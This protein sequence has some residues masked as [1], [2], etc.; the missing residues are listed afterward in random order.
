MKQFFALLHLQLLSR[1]ADL[2]PRNLKANLRGKK[3]KTIGMAFAYV[4]LTA[5]LLGLVIYLETV[6]L[7]VLIQMNAPDMLIT[8]AVS[9]SV[10]C[11]L[12]MAFFFIMSSLY[13]GRDTAFIASLPV[14]TRTVL[15]A[16][17]IQ[18]WI[19]EAG[20]AAFFILPASILYGIRLHP[21]P[22]FYLRMILVWLGVPVLPIVIV[23]FLST[24]LIR[25]SA[26]WKKRE[27]VVTVGGI[28]LLVAYMLLCMNLGS[29]TGDHPEE[30]FA[31]FL[32]SNMTRIQ[33]LTR[34]FP[35][36]GWAA[37][38]LLGDWG[39]L[40]LFLAVCAA[41]MAFAVWA[42]GF[43]YH[44]LSLLQSE[45]PAQRGK[46][47]AKALSFSGSSAFG[48]CCQREIRQILRVP[49]YA[50]NIL[51]IS[52]M[53]LL[54]V[55]VM[56][57]SLS[58]S[59]AEQGDTIAQLLEGVGGGTVLAV[60]AAIMAFMAGMNPAL[61]SAVTRE[62]KGHDYLTALPVPPR[63]IVL[64]KWT[65]GMVL[66]LIGCVPAAVLLGVLVPGYGLHAFLAFLV[67]ALFACITGCIAL[68]NDTAHP[69]LDWLTETEAIKQKSGALI[70]ILVSWALLGLLAVGSFFLLR[71][72]CGLWAYAAILLA[73]LSAGSALALR[74]LL[75][76][77]DKKY[78][79]G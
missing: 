29:I 4:F 24:L 69:K 36:A 58:R 26:L 44:D 30:F 67:T 21:D 10:L 39:R 22:L 63:V 28:V 45:T 46:K 62:G 5:Y 42:L 34:I 40:L 37:G 49:A 75:R 60:M 25:L 7:D 27:A 65:V 12:I 53:P 70:G 16:K 41:A 72:G 33:A 20:A 15:G 32:S 51:P 73:L 64:A 14:K 52:F 47:G 8:L 35:P 71:A 1:F 6:I 78:A 54:M 57:L 50:T 43:V 79:Q 3:A 77:A 18:I 76:T 48:A 13:F 17:L 19:S 66:S 23:A 31:Q 59:M 61:S 68:A 74:F 38:G 56:A 55:G 11:T 2:K 9:T